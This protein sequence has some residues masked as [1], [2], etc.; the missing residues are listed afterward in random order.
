MVMLKSVLASV[1]TVV[2][3]G[4]LGAASAAPLPTTA[5]GAYTGNTFNDVSRPGGLSSL[6]FGDRLIAC[7]SLQDKL[8]LVN[9]S[10]SPIRA[11]ARIRYAIGRGPY[12]E[13]RLSSTL[14]PGQSVVPGQAQAPHFRC[15]VRVMF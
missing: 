2:A 3:L 9:V 1:V 5:P 8:V 10:S 7:A 12:Q 14:K 15:N 13:Y 11:G 4:S 6:N